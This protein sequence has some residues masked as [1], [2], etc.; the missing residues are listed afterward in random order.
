MGESGPYRNVGE[1]MKEEGRAE[2]EGAVKRLNRAASG[3]GG[4][5]SAGFW[6]GEVAAEKAE[7]AS[8]YGPQALYTFPIYTFPTNT[9]LMP[10]NSLPYLV[11]VPLFKSPRLTLIT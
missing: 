2:M 8:C 1:A 10:L 4:H 3:A 11:H 5:G 7:A 6:M 9:Y